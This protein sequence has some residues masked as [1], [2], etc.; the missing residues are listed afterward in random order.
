M[1][2]QIGSYV[3][4]RVTLREMQAKY[5]CTIK[6]I[7]QHHSEGISHQELDYRAYIRLLTLCHS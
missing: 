3:A 2:L 6:H 4:I 5:V 1:H 7:E